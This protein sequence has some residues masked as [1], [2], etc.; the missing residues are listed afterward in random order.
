MRF[1]A[2]GRDVRSAEDTICV[3]QLARPGYLSARAMALSRLT[4]VPGLAVR[5]PSLT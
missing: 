3:L 2:L 4:A 1:I 5:E